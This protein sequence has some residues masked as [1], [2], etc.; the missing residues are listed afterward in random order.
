[1]QTDHHVNP[2]AQHMHNAAPILV[3]GDAAFPAQGV[4]AEVLNLQSLAGYTTGGTIHSSPTISSDSRPIPMQGRS[5]R[6]ASDLAKGFDVPIVHVNADDVEA[7]MSAVHFALDFRVKF[8]RDVLIDV[9]GYRRF[10]H[11]EQDEPAYTQPGIYEKIKNP[12]DR[13]R[14]FRCKSRRARASSRS[15]KPISSSKQQTTRLAEQH[16]ET[17]QHASLLINEV[18]DRLCDG[19]VD[20]HARRRARNCSAGVTSSSDVP[21]GFAISTKLER[22]F[23]KRED[24]L[25]ATG[26]SRLGPRRVVCL[27][28]DDLAKERR[29]ALPAKTPSAGR[30]VIA[31]RCCTMPTPTT[32]YVPLQHLSN[33]KASFEIYNSPLSEYACVGFE[34]GYSV[35]SE[36]RDGVVGSAV[37]RF[38]TTARRSSSINSWPPASRS[39]IR[40][41]A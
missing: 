3:H 1:M 7:C 21:E 6:Y 9:I 34:Y 39:G 17:K 35:V 16:A 27:R 38:L 4:V 36:E 41:R 2:P 40:N 32:R 37:R 13:A 19:R 29:C 8:G 12:S 10:G 25:E 20:R 23:S 22:Q 14:A 15:N 5:T 30:S 11:N 28:V 24:E 33:A 31:M 26:R 18:D